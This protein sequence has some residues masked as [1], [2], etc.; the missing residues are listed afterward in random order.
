VRAVKAIGALCR[1]IGGTIRAV[2]TA[3]RVGIGVLGLGLVIFAIVLVLPLL[4]VQTGFGPFASVEPSPAASASASAEPSASEEPSAS[5]SGDASVEPTGEATPSEAA[6][7][8][9]LP[10]TL[11]A[12]GGAIVHTAD[13]RVGTHGTYDRIVFEYLE[14]GS[15]AFEM[16]STSPPFTKDPSGQPMTV[17]GST[18][19]LITLNGATKLADDGS[20]TYTGP[21]SFQPGFP[22]LAHLTE[23]GDFE[24]VNSWY[25]GLNGGDC[26]RA[27]LLAD[28]SRIVIDVQH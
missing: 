16:R 28:P 1:G 3:V 19:M 10:M 6:Y 25:V 14:D 11:A 7:V 20:L 8:C 2:Q 4:G 17:H 9:G 12:S 24:A 15:P 22:Q 21:A 27:G 5:A 13:V 23:R 18:V 26:I